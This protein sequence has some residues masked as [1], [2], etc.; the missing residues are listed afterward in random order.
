M[1]TGNMKTEPI[2]ARVYALYKIVKNAGEIKKSDIQKKMEPDIST[3]G[4]SYFSI[5]FSAATELNIIKT[6]ENGM[7]KVIQDFDSIDDFKK[8]VC[9]S[10]EKYKDS[11][12][13]KVT[14]A[15]ILMNKDVLDEKLTNNNFINKIQKETKENIDQTEMLGWRFWAKFLGFGYEHDMYF[16]P[17]AY[18]FLKTILT[19][20]GLEKNVEIPI[21]KFINKLEKYGKI[22]FEEDKKE[23]TLCLSAALRQLHENKEIELKYQND[24]GKGVTL[25]PSNQYFSQPVTSIIYKGVS[26]NE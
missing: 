20:C 23:F 17:N 16:L 12:F 5:I 13:Y 19:E 22:L 3:G 8:F 11:H 4:T 7:I 10:L 25:Y 1:F 6:E 24:Q 9:L 14:K 26:I 2:P 18:V 15:I 21:E